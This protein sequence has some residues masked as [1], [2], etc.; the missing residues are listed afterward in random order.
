MFFGDA[1]QA[2]SFADYLV[3]FDPQQRIH[4][5]YLA[6]A[7]ILALI[8]YL[9]FRKDPDAE[10]AGADKGFGNFIFG[11]GAYTH[12]SAVQDYAFALVNI[13][14]YY[15][16]IAQ[17]LFSSNVA[18]T[19]MHEFFTGLFGALSSPVLTGAWTK[20]AFTLCS[21]IAFDFAL[22]WQHY[23][24]HK[25]PILWHFHKVH[26][27]AEVLNPITLYRMHPVDL[28]ISAILAAVFGGTFY[29]LFWYLSGNQPQEYLVLGLNVVV[30]L[31]YIFGYNLRHSQIW[32]NYPVWLSHIIV[33]PAQHQVHHSIAPK[34]WD[35][36]MGLIFAFWDKLFG[37]LYV[38][39][40]YEKLNYGISQ[41]EPN[42]FNSVWD[43]YIAPFKWTWASLRKPA[44]RRAIMP[45]FIFMLLLGLFF[46]GMYHGIQG[47]I[48]KSVQIED[49]TWVEIGNAQKNGYDT[50]IIPTG[51]T[52][53]GGAHL[54][55]GKHNFIIRYTTDKIARQVGRA[56]VAPVL[57]YVPEGT[58]NP[59]DDNM[60]VTGTLSLT[61]ATYE[62]VLRDTAESYIQHGF[63]HIFFIGESG[64]N[65]K[66]QEK[67]AK[68]LS[69]KGVV[70]IGDYYGPANGQIEW[71][72]NEGYTEAQI[73]HHAG[74]RDTSELMV[75]KP[76]AVRTHPPGTFGEMGE[77]G[78]YR[79]A[80]RKI[81]QK[82]LDLKINAAI[83]QITPYLEDRKSPDKEAPTPIPAKASSK[84]K[85]NDG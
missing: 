74:M 83:R 72:K 12:K 22:F 39:K 20:I 84:P 19:V 75:V 67:V 3:I 52:E 79:L 50:V 1:F 24:M 32:F 11:R 43:L 60:R 80:T 55:E 40:S 4:V 36:N 41:K 29:G 85:T 35:K 47:R 68:E 18:A 23:L 45:F 82:M 15:I 57:G 33:S 81:G 17:L 31:F 65:Q 16:V 51:G 27:S 2:K 7:L 76:D 58:I 10:T 78:D 37:T 53:Q 61:E 38:P 26:H 21:I 63:K 77:N 73:G 6:S 70:H 59:P 30:F 5:L 34:H 9:T 8:S 44:E 14:I 56:F 71:L 62:G 69:A 28:A 42:P 48:L 49:L 25:I 54:A 66:G 46:T 13:V 64:P